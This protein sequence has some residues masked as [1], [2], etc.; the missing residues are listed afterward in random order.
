V[1]LCIT[2]DLFHVLVAFRCSGKVK[3]VTFMPYGRNGQYI[4]EGISGA[5]MY[6]IGGAAA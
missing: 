6:T 5:M 3:P 1:T 2:A 4:I